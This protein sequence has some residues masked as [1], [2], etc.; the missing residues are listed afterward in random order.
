MKRNTLISVYFTLIILT[1]NCLSSFSQV[2]KDIAFLKIVDVL[3]S[4]NAIKQYIDRVDISKDYKL[5]LIVSDFKDSPILKKIIENDRYFLAPNTDIIKSDAKFY[6]YPGKLIVAKDS[7]YMEF[8]IVNKRN[9]KIEG[10]ISFTPNKPG[11]KFDI[12]TAKNTSTISSYK[13][14]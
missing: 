4:Q 6:L 11:E 8:E 2:Q 13:L 7:C 10:K 9:L 14:K 5:K 12:N 3:S 1:F